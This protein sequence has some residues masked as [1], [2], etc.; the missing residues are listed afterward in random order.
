MTRMLPL[1]GIPMALNP[2]NMVSGIPEHAPF[3][4]VRQ[5]YFDA[6]I[7]AGGLPVAI[8]AF[9]ADDDGTEL[10]RHYVTMLDG[11]LLAGGGD[12]DAVLWGEAN[13]HGVNINPVRD[14]IEVA[15]C[16]RCMASDIPIFG[17]CRGIQMIAVALGGDI[18]QDYTL[19][20]FGDHR[21]TTHDV[22]IAEGTNLHRILATQRVAVN[23]THHQIVRKL[24]DDFVVSAAASSDKAVEAIEY[25]GAHNNWVVGVQWHPETMH[26]DHFRALYGAF[27]AACTE[28]MR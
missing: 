16:R 23:S 22:D 1:I 12:P 11:L 8:P 7:A 5:S 20:G 25:A 9:S 26:E 4:Y 15:L 6:V 14:S 27:V 18:W 24:P 17:V 21:D 10:I 2:R 13:T 28:R 19:G 3:Q